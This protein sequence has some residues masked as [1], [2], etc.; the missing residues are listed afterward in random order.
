MK[1]RW[2]ERWKEFDV[3]LG[4]KSEDGAVLIISKEFAGEC[5]LL[6]GQCLYDMEMYFDPEE[7]ISVVTGR[8]LGADFEEDMIGFLAE[9]TPEEIRT[10]TKKVS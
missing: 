4:E 7:D 1:I 6:S 3:E 9:F 8:F 10:Y 2:N 5:S